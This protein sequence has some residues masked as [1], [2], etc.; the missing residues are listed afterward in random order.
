MEE[1]YK[2]I[3]TPGWWIGVV[4]V[5]IVINLIST[6]LKVSIEAISARVGGAWSRAA[7][8]AAQR[9]AKWI[10]MLRNDSHAQV[11]LHAR[12]QRCRLQSIYMLL[13]CIA[14][15]VIG[16]LVG[17]GAGP[18]S[19]VTSGSIPKVAYGPLA[20]AVFAFFG[21]Y[22]SMVDASKCAGL[23]KEAM[24]DYPLPYNNH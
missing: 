22:S 18:I 13:M 20:G 16:L 14:L 5:G 21:S 15:I 11:I 2:S 24:E 8:D 17:W 7:T 3:S 23:L 4:F 10:E 19:A 1:L 6:Y 9:R 12:E